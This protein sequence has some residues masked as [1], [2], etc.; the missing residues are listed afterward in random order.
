MVADARPEAKA[1]LRRGSAGRAQAGLSWHTRAVDDATI[2]ALQAALAASPDNAELRGVLIGARL[3]RGEHE[4]GVAL[5]EGVAPDQL[6]KSAQLVAVRLCLGAGRHE[7]GLA[8]VEA[9]GD[10]HGDGSEALLLRAR[11]LLG[12][13][14]LD[15]ARAA[16]RAALERNA[17]VEDRELELALSPSPDQ[18]PP[19]QSPDGRLRVVATDD[20]DDDELRRLLA[21]SQEAIGFDDVGGL[22]EVKKQVR[23]RIITPFQKP[24]IFA[25]FKRK[26]GG[27]IMMYGP[28]GCGKT[29]LARA[30]AGEVDA[31]FLNVRISDVLDMYIGESERKLHALFERAREQVPAVLFFDELEALAGKRKYHRESTTAKLVSLFLSEMD[32]FGQNNSGVLLIGATNVPWSIDPA[33]LRPGRFDR[34]LFVPPPDAAA[35]AAI[36]TR[37][38]DGRPTA[39]DITV[40]AIVRRTSG[41]SGADLIN[42]VD[43]AIDE[44]IEAS[45]ESGEELPLSQAALVEAAR[46]IKATTHEWLSTARNYVRYANDGGRYDEVI[47]F[48]EQHTK[49]KR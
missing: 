21:P 43:S 1:L 44:V 49:R 17:T 5:L 39:P 31:T 46:Q 47:E 11:L 22:D 9:H 8:F 19:S 30:T 48:I 26:V 45:L 15:E 12:L 25:R 14:R 36:L 27:G 29:M 20:T 23:R 42:I 6:T 4:A 18:T 28:P 38:L 40:D 41:Y 10:T 16:Y 24:T 7:L 13:A 35:R 37:A 34:T 2:A 32:G 33:F 3:E